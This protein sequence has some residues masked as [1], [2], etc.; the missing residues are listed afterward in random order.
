M[1]VYDLRLI[2]QSFDWVSF[3]PARL[4]GHGHLATIET[5]GGLS[6]P[7]ECVIT[8]DREEETEENRSPSGDGRR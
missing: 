8:S 1:D 2:D 6:E 4:G 5:D 3:H 7:D